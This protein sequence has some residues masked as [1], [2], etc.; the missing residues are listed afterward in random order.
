MQINNLSVPFPDLESDVLRRL[1]FASYER[2][3]NRAYR[4]RLASMGNTAQGVFWRSQSSQF[5]RFNA[6]LSLVH[7]LRGD[8]PTTIADIGCGYGAMLDFI[9]ASSNFQHIE[10]RGVDIN[11]AMIAACHKK[12]PQQTGIFSV[13]SKPHDMV[14]FCLFSGTFNLTH[15]DDPAMWNNYIFSSLTRCMKH[16]CLLYTSPS[17]RDG[18]LSRMPSSA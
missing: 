1:L 18:L 14:D 15:S 12:F 6:L 8:K 7:Q 5:A 10:Y 16:T 4:N 3:L 2:Q 9:N 17:P 13:G 11:R